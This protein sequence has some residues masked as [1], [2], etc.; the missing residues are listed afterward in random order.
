[1]ATT[2]YDQGLTDIIAGNIRLD[3][4][5]LVAMLCDGN[6]VPNASTQVTVDDVTDEV[7][8]VVGTGYERKIVTGKQFSVDTGSGDIIF[9]C[10]DLRWTG[11]QVNADVRYVIMYR[12]SFSDDTST[13][14]FAYEITPIQTVGADLLI[15]F[16][17]GIALEVSK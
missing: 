15:E 1:M 2:I 5:I 11:I 16:P 3:N 14:L 9:T 6:Y 4:D 12:Q 7:T 8:N 13:L 17:N 10:D